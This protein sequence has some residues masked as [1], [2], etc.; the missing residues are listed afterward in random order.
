MRNTILALAAAGPLTFVVLTPA[1]A[2]GLTCPDYPNMDRCPI[3]GVYGNPTPRPS[4]YQ[5]P[6][7]QI[8]HA[9]TYHKRYPYNG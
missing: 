2:V 3:D 7:R 4:S 6:P 1:L 9:H 8:R 5:V